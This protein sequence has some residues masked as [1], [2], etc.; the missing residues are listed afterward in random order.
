M[1]QGTLFERCGWHE[2]GPNYILSDDS[3][4]ETSDNRNS[5]FDG[6]KVSALNEPH[7]TDCTTEKEN[8]KPNSRK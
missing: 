5:S 2:A 1:K 3:Y 4:S 7:N 6:V 8:M